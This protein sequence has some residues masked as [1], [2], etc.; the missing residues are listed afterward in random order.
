MS[1][2]DELA[3]ILVG[4]STVGFIIFFGVATFIPVALELLGNK[5]S[6]AELLFRY[7]YRL[8]S[9]IGETWSIAFFI[10]LSLSFIVSGSLSLFY[11]LFDK[12]ILLT[13]AEGISVFIML[14]SAAYIL[15]VS[16]CSVPTKEA[17]LRR[18]IEYSIDEQKKLKKRNH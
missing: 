13:I 3:A 8:I 18:I 2:P 10:I 11:I 12:I 6:A 7:P 1:S 16:I 4:L 15:Y 5:Q 14:I 17:D 9:K